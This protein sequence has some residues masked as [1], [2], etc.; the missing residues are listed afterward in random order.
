M[1]LEYVERVMTKYYESCD[2]WD[3]E[4]KVRYFEPTPEQLRSALVE[5]VCGKYETDRIDTRDRKDFQ[6]FMC[7][8]ISDH[9]LEDKLIDYYFEEIKEYFED[10]AT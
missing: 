6:K 4:E 8:F 2:E 1:V 10:Q 3:Y 7:D 9:D 5:I